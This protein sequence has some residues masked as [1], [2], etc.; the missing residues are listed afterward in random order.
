MARRSPPIPF[1]PLMQGGGH[2]EG[3]RSGTLNVPG[4]IGLATALKLCVETMKEE[5]QR[6]SKLRNSLIE[7][8]LKTIPDS[9]LNGH[10]TMRIHNN[11]SL[12]FDYISA[13]D[14]L[15]SLPEIAF[16]TGSACSSNSAESSYVVKALGL[17]EDEVR[18]TVRFGLG[19]WTTQEE[20]DKTVDMLKRAV[21]GLRLKSLKY[22]MAFIKGKN[23]GH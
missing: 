12:R 14:L 11:V 15:A 8:V 4:I 16:S 17:T 18:Q 9:H 2:E 22:E 10:P 23:N 5:S 6:L 3:R 20:I 21:E 7:R 1:K 13:D 19:R